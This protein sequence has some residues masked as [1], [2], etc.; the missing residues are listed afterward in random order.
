MNKE[1]WVLHGPNLN[2]LGEREPDIY[3]SQKLDQLIEQ[4]RI[5]AEELG[6]VLPSF[7]SNH[8]GDLIDKLQEI[9]N[10]SVGVLINAG[11]LTHTSIAL[12]DAVKSL[13]IPVVEIHISDTSKR[14]TFRHNSYLTS[15][16]AAT[17]MGE[18]IKS[19]FK[20]INFLS[21]YIKGKRME[22]ETLDTDGSVF[23]V[24]EQIWFDDTDAAGVMFN[25]NLFRICHRAYER[26]LEHI[27]FPISKILSEKKWKMPIVHLEGDFFLP[28]T[29]GMK[30]L[31]E[32]S[33]TKI[34]NK[35][36]NI[37]YE[38]YNN[39]QKLCAKAL[40]TH[41]AID[42]TEDTKTMPAKLRVALS[43]VQSK[44]N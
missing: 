43:S 3:G 22:T 21:D 24:E 27:G 15:A 1:I 39:E 4:V 10:T 32:V 8:E 13:D 14:E 30:I 20:G 9:R 40:S 12:Y 31:I 6:F 28:M 42:V 29:T 5:A 17:F 37:G 23:T 26:F 7:Q 25:A 36:F 41:I 38:V 44:T 34:G 16:S 11:A 35:S 33:I 18:G 2:L 19:Y